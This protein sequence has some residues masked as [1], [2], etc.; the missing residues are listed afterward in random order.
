M[1][2]DCDPDYALIGST[3]AVTPVMSTSC[4]P[5]DV[6]MAALGSNLLSPVTLDSMMVV[7]LNSVPPHIVLKLVR[8]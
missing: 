6:C 4:I 1:P 8:I 2:T 3:F 5:G 7:Q